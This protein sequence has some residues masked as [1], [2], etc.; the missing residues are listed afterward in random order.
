MVK[1]M[2]A[3]KSK[4]KKVSKNNLKNNSPGKGPSPGKGQSP[5]QGKPPGILKRP[6]SL[7]LPKKDDP[8]LSLEEKMEHN[9]QDFFGQLECP[10]EGSSLG[11]ACKSQ[12][13]TQ[14]H[15]PEQP[16]RQALQERGQSS[17]R[18]SFWP[19]TSG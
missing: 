7:A 6:A 12:E 17:A 11:K 5:G 8:G 2:K 14:R 10:T 16:A 18:N 3:M 13:S 15:K 4:S 9:T 19:S 1:A